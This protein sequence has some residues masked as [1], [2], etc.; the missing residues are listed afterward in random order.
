ME[1]G[2][3]CDWA[4]TKRF[5]RS[6]AKGQCH[7]ETKCTFCGGGIHFDGAASRLTC[8]YFFNIFISKQLVRLLSQGGSSRV[9][10]PHV[11]T[12]VHFRS[13]DKMAVTQFDAPRKL[14]GCMFYRT[15]VI[16]DESFTSRGK[17]FLTFL[18]PETL[19][20]TR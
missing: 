3:K 8:F 2:T 12:R 18:V 10:Y 13:R 16:A 1:L 11:V 19:T 15:G 20:L 17:A 6:E 14:P 4:F 9:S 5:S 7:G